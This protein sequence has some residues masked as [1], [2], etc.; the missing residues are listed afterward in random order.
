MQIVGGASTRR[1]KIGNRFVIRLRNTVLKKGK[2]RLGGGKLQAKAT[3]IWQVLFFLL[4]FA[5][6]LS[7]FEPRYA[8]SRNKR[9]TGGGGGLFSFVGRFRSG[10]F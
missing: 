7:A 5:A 10:L 3:C 6:A 8:Q 1:Q 9:N 2:G 4:R